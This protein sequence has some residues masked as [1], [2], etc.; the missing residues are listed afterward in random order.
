ML[1]MRLVDLTASLQLKPDESRR[2]GSLLE[3]GGALAMELERLDSLGVYPITRA[4]SE[5]PPRYRERLKDSAPPVLFCAGDY[6]LMQQPGI[7][8]VGSRNLGMEGEEIA[9][10]LGEAC[11]ISGVIL[12]SGGARGTDALSMI[13]ALENGGKVVGILAESLVKTIRQPAS[14]EA[15]EAG[16]LCFITPYHPDAP[17]SVGNAMGRNAL[18]Y[19]M[20]DHAIVVSSD[21]GKGGTWE[22]ATQAMRKGLSPV[23]VIE[24]KNVPPGNTELIQRGA[25]PLQVPFTFE[26]MDIK[27]HLDSMVSRKIDLPG[28]S[29]GN[30]RT[31]TPESVSVQMDLIPGFAD[32]PQKTNKRKFSRKS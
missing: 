23:H 16:R 19:A 24:H 4:D 10:K 3:R 9:R 5:Y 2:I 25:I 32:L 12:I 11:A 28:G 29:G 26:A 14:R 21:L 7:A 30:D 1:G 27:E 20:A 18:I 15:V 8:V 22:G 13:S 6:R 17:F 31:V